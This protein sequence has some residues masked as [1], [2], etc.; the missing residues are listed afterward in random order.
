MAINKLV[1][2]DLVIEDLILELGL[3]SNTYIPTFRR[4]FK[5]AYGFFDDI[6]S[7]LTSWIE[8]V[9]VDEC[10]SFNV[11][12]NATL[13]YTMV[14]GDKGCDCDALLNNL[15][16]SNTVPIATYSDGNSSSDVKVYRSGYDFKYEDN[17]VVFTSQNLIGQ[18]VT[19]KWYGYKTECK[20]R[21]MINE[22]A[23]DACIAYVKH[24][25]AERSLFSGKNSRL[26][27]NM[28]VR[29]ESKWKRTLA[30][31]RADMIQSTP[32]E[33]RQMA[34]LNNNGSIPTNDIYS[35]NLLGSTNW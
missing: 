17:K 27:D 2:T 19:V 29:L 31:C 14:P 15:I 7:G 12:E 28:I 3:E 26:S 13:L 4:W 5:K 21:L 24:M 20:G 11:P 30:R 10:N 6:T 16:S 34:A 35:V 32:G 23:I 1:S 18:T 9:Q 25:L 33:E 22:Y 8:V